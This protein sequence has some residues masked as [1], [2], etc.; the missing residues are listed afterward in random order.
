MNTR[1]VPGFANCC[2]SI[3]C[4]AERNW[5]DSDVVL[6]AGDDHGNDDHGL[7]GAG[8]FR[9]HADP[10]HLRFDLVEAGRELP[11]APL[12]RGSAARRAHERIDDVADAQRELLHQ[13]E[14]PA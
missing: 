2:T 12:P 5:P 8:G 6:H 9:G 1:S 11:G 14:T 3:N 10:H 13:A 7:G 4:S